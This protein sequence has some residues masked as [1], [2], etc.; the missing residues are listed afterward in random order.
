MIYSLRDADKYIYHYTK[1]CTAINFVLK[2]LTI[3]LGSFAGTNDPKESKDWSFNLGTRTNR[4]LGPYSLAELSSQL[5]QR[6]KSQA[7]LACFSSDR[8]PLSGDHTRDITSRGLAKPRMWAQYSSNHSGVCLVLDRER[9]LLAVENTF[10]K[11]MK[12]SGKVT[13]KDQYFVRDLSYHEYM[14][15]IDKYEEVGVVEYAKHHLGVHVRALFFEKMLDWRD[16]EEWRIVAMAESEED[17]FLP[18]DSSLVGVVHGASI[19]PTDSNTI[20]SLTAG[21]PVTHVALKWNNSAPWY[22]LGRFL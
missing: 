4:D 1:A 2:N 17:M 16:E 5:S 3:K 12:W 7:R 22:D 20:R 14:I 18:I 21:M 19:S 8:G 9:T 13:Y 6:L 10:P 15:D 11:C